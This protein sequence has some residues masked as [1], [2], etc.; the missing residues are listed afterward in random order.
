[1]RSK[2]NQGGK[3]IPSMIPLDDILEKAKLQDQKIGQW[4]PGIGDL[5]GEADY[6]E[7]P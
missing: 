7:V 1:M 4:L 2:R 6:K 5:A 3:A